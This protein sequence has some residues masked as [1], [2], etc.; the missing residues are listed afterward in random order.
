MALFVCVIA[1]PALGGDATQANTS[2]PQN[3][4]HK[5]K[6][7]TD[8]LQE[9]KEQNPMQSLLAALNFTGGISAGYFYTSNS[10]HGVSD[11]EWMLSNMLMEVSSKVK[12]SPVGFTAA[13]G[14]TST[15]SILGSPQTTHSIDV[16][17]ASIN[18][19]PVDGFTAKVGLLQCNS[20]Y[21]SSYTY[22]NQN[23]FLGAI[24]SQQ[25]YNAYGAQIGYDFKQV[26]V[27]A[28]YYKDRLADDEY[29]TEENDPNESWE[30]AV[31]GKIMD[32]SISV[33]HY[34]IESQRNLTGTLIARTIGEVDLV[35]NLDYWHWDGNMADLHEDDSSIGGAFYVVPHFGNF[36]L[37]LRLE[38]ID[39]GKSAIYLDN[40][41]A[42]TI[43]AATLS[44]T[45]RF[46]SNVY[47][48]TDIGY[49]RADDG[50][51]DNNGNLKGD[52]ICLAA[53]IGYTF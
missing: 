44:P 23:T 38:Y 12:N 33:Y 15:P 26:H 8:D 29:V 19:N 22:G 36:S 50:F 32:T 2:E 35:L 51:M 42:H 34:Q 28:G 37:P 39:Q 10:G 13:L 7:T 25:P 46:Q 11:N 20:G 30:V 5:F 48:R 6:N 3:Q 21:E 1:K 53:E 40:E 43:Y 27:A 14:E 24:A 41:N 16:E 4:V 18:L 52:R 47:L 45:Y 49:V 9:K 31:S 17:Y